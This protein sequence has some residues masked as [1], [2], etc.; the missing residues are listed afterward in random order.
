MTRKP[1]GKFKVRRCYNQY[2]VSQL[3]EI[4]GKVGIGPFKRDVQRTEYRF[5]DLKGGTAYSDTQWGVARF[6]SRED[7]LGFIEKVKSNEL[8]CETIFVD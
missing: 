6:N 4:T 5:C 2:F 1:L 7:A 8:D 3:I